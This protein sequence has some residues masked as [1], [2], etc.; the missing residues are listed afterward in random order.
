[1]I[2]QKYLLIFLSLIMFSCN[3]KTKVQN[4]TKEEQKVESSLLKFT[5]GVRSILHDTKGNYWFGSHQE[6]VALF[7][8]KSFKYFTI[9]DGLSDNQVRSIQE[10]HKGNIWFGTGNGVSSYDGTEIIMHPLQP[11]II[12]N[13]FFQ[14]KWT[15]ADHDLWFNAGQSTGVYKYN[16]QALNYLEFPNSNINT[17]NNSSAVTGITKGKNDQLWI[18]SYNGVIGFDGSTFTFINSETL[19]LTKE[20]G[21]LHIRSIL[22]DSKGNLWIGNNSIGVLLFNGY[23]TINFSE[24]MNLVHS[25]SS[26][27]GSRSYSGTL[28]HVFAIGEDDQGNIWFGDRDTG[29]WKYD[30]ESMTNYNLKDG[31][32]VTHIWDIYQDRNGELLFAMGNGSVYVFTG[33][34]FERKY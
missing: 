33:N 19:G 24:K 17:P 23:T 10:D 3:S 11:D 29:A 34:S 22:E 28:E 5:S 15:K 16:G 14:P 31:F 30:G 13:D 7:D 26:L 4:Q 18:A 2:K 20:N 21:Y 6:G 12:L 25:K 27:N 8:G 32:P 9:Q 1:M